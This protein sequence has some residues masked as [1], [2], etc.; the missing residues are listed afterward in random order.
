[1]HLFVTQRCASIPKSLITKRP[2]LLHDD[3]VAFS[4]IHIAQEAN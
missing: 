1:M 4:A 3:E 2:E